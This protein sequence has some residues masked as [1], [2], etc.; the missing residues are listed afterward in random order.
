M[1][2]NRYQSPK[3]NRQPM[4]DAE[5]ERYAPSVFATEKHEARGDRYQFISSAEI[6]QGL[7]SQGFL[8]IRAEQSRANDTSKRGHTR[9]IVTF[10]QVSDIERVSARYVPGQHQFIQGGRS[11]RSCST[12]AT[13]VPAPTSCTPASSDWSARTA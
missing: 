3:V 7:R 5:I 4:T 6:V 9:H 13:M 1:L 11:T 8:P 12:T 10:R 2:P